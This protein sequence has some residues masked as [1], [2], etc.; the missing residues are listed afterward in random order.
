MLGRRVGNNVL[1]GK[2]KA[3]RLGSVLLQ[4]LRQCAFTLLPPHRPGSRITCVIA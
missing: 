1:L 3:Q 4:Q 2:I